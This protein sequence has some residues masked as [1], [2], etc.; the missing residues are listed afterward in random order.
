M[1]WGNRHEVCSCNTYVAEALCVLLYCCCVLVY[2]CCVAA[3]AVVKALL[4]EGSREAVPYAGK[5]AEGPLTSVTPLV[6]VRPTAAA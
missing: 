1:C 5:A 4:G 2:C 3:G 6:Q